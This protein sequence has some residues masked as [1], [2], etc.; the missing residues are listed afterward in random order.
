MAKL[1]LTALFLLI[2]FTLFAGDVKRETYAFGIQGSDT[3]K[4]DKYYV[5]NGNA[6]PRPVVIFAFGGGF[7]TG[8]RASSDYIDFFKHLAGQGLIVVSTDYRTGLTKLDP[9]SVKTAADF[10]TALQHA[11]GLAV[12]DFYNATAFVI[13][14]CGKW[15]GD[16]GKIIA[17]GSSAGA[18]TAL[19]AEYMLCNGSPLASLLPDGFN[20]A[21]VISFAGAICSEGKPQWKEKPC[22]MMLFQGDADNIVPFGEVTVGDKGLYGSRFIASQLKKMGIP[23]W[24]Y[25]KRGAGHELAG[26]PM[27]YEKEEIDLV[28]FV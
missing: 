21:G 14:N 2:T 13:E 6:A 22:P 3:L 7:R 16:P 23:Y 20:Y 5:E 18:I 1:N 9:A 19:Q 17:C 15:G 26:T 27:V 28:M 4:L 24:F 25:T 10:T 12:T 11:I 8:N